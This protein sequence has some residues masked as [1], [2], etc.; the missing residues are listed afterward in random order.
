M[1]EEYARRYGGT[2][3]TIGHAEEARRV[4]H[5]ELPSDSSRPVVLAFLGG[6]E[7]RRW[8]PLREIGEALRDLRRA[9]TT[10]ELVVHTPNPEPY[11]R[12]L[13]L[14]P[15]MR[16]GE[17]LSAEGV[18]RVQETADVLVHVESFAE[19][20]RRYTRF[21]LSTKIPQYMMAGGCIFAYGPGEVASMRYIADGGFGVVVPERSPS[22]LRAGLAKLIRDP[23]LRARYRERAREAG[24]ANHEANGQR[25]KF[26]QAVL[27]AHRGWGQRVPLA[28]RDYR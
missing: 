7:P 14:P 1:T 3:Q 15:V 10:G 26:R 23:E 27:A 24:I 13:T 16:L 22:D 4:P 20:D 28:E 21:S 5:R 2:F 19:P 9:G 6:L 8:E 11:V 17:P 18:R 12:R 25:E